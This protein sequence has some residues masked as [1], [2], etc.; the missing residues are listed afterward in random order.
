MLKKTSKQDIVTSLL[1]LF[2]IFV[3]SIM[4]PIITII[5]PWPMFF[6]AIF[7]FMLGNNNNKQI[8]SIFLSGIVGISSAFIF[9]KS[10]N[11]LLPIIGETPAIVLS[12]ITILTIIIIGGNFFP[13]F[14]NN[15][16]FAYLTISMINMAII[17]DSTLGRLLMLVV[18]GT[19]ILTGIMIIYWIVNKLFKVIQ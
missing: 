9:M 10:L 12:F 6:V 5:S 11:I 15:I 19:I 4:T 7:F 16:A 14:L 1:I 18:G 3:L 13:L 17:I 2:W 8:I